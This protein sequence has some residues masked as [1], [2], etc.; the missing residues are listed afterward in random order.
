M[1]LWIKIDVTDN[2]PTLF[3][4]VAI[5]NV[6][7]VNFVYCGKTLLQDARRMHIPDGQ[8]QAIKLRV[9]WSFFSGSHEVHPSIRSTQ[10]KGI[11]LWHFTNPVWK[12]QAH[13]RVLN[14]NKSTCFSAESKQDQ[15]PTINMSAFLPPSRFSWGGGDFQ[16]WVWS[17]ILSLELIDGWPI[18]FLSVVVSYESND[19]N[20]SWVTDTSLFS[21]QSFELQVWMTVCQFYHIVVESYAKIIQIFYIRNALSYKINLKLIWKK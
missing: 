2:L 20:F 11:S 17:L 14:V 7:I 12:T 13:G 9:F 16:V 10:C 21:V 19:T 1:V 8:R 18:M 6:N 5:Q 15:L 3:Q 4:N